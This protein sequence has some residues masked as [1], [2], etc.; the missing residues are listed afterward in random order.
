[1]KGDREKCIAGGMD[2]YLTKPIKADA[3]FAVIEKLMRTPG[4][5]MKSRENTGPFSKEKPPVD[6]DIFDRSKA[7][8]VVAGDMDLFKEI[9]HLFLSEVP[10]NLSK[11]RDAMERGDARALEQI[12]HYLKGSIGNFGAQRAHEAAYRL[13]LLG[14]EER[15]SEA[16]EALCVLEKALE[17]LEAAMQNALTEMKK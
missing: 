10:E 4:D 12:A 14:R 15:V 2:D 13:E 1:M 6:K 8:E 11:I 17:E 16:D 3:L 9:A 7:L 5:K